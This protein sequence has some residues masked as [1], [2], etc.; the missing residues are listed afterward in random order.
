MEYRESDFDISE[1]V[2][3]AL[4]QLTKKEREVIKLLYWKNYLPTTVAKMF[5]VRRQTVHVVEQRAL[6]KLK[7]YFSE[8]DQENLAVTIVRGLAG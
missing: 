4:A 5:G 3:R 2:H 6:K 1:R 8:N 7:K